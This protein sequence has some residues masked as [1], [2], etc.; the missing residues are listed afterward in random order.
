MPACK[1]QVVRRLPRRVE[2]SGEFTNTTAGENG[3]VRGGGGAGER[4]GISIPRSNGGSQRGGSAAMDILSGAHASMIA[5]QRP[6]LLS[7]RQVVPNPRE[8]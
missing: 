6:F 2:E 1:M 5:L 4:M 7:Q 3:S 8:C